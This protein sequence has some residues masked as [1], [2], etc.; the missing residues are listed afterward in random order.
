MTREA[1]GFSLIEVVAALVV[2]VV[3]VIPI[4][5]FFP[6]AVSDGARARDGQTAGA[7]GDRIRLAAEVAISGTS[8]ATFSEAHWGMGRDGSNLHSVGSVAA[9]DE[10]FLCDVSRVGNYDPA[11]GSIDV[12]VIISWPFRIAGKSAVMET[13]PSARDRRQYRLRLQTQ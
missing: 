6:V 10:Y 1:G 13:V 9:P 12:Q 5:T 7:L 2:A 3:A 11:S 4:L 8:V